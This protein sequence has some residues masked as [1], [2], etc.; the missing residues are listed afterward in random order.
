MDNTPFHKNLNDSFCAA[1]ST[2]KLAA[3]QSF[4]PS[5]FLGC[6]RALFFVVARIVFR[7]FTI[8]KKRG[9]RAAARIYLSAAPAMDI[10]SARLLRTKATAYKRRER[11][12]DICH[13]PALF[14]CHCK[15]TCSKRRTA[16]LAASAAAERYNTLDLSPKVVRQKGLPAPCWIPRVQ[17]DCIP[18]EL[19]LS[20]LQPCRRAK[21][22]L[23][24]ACKIARML[25][26]FL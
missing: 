1:I 5:S 14:C 20:P 23:F 6:F 10:A 25:P 24:C 3:K 22:P 9:V 17:E 7:M 4:H 11:A 18:S 8:G 15:G 12:L 2:Q 16:S 19:L 26:T 21:R 13:V